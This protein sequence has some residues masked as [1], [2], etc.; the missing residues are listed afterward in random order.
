[1][2]RDT[3]AAVETIK[4][5]IHVEPEIGIILGSGLGK[6]VDEF[7]DLVSIGFADI[8]NFPVPAVE[9]HKGEVVAVVLMGLG[10]SF[11]AT[12]YPAWRAARIDPAEALRYE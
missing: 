5:N 11:L 10:L 4:K 3:E 6:L 1:M 8:P 9:G 7:D 2:V 12:I